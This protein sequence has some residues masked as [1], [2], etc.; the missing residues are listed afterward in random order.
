MIDKYSKIVILGAG[1]GGL[2]TAIA[3]RQK[4]FN[5]ISIYERRLKATTIG[6]GLVL[7]SNATKILNK[8]K[9]L[10]ELEKVGG[11]L[12]QMQRWT[13]NEEFLGAINVSK[14]N[15]SI[16]FKSYS[17]SRT[18]LQSI[19]LKKVYE[20][21]ISINYNHNALNISYQDNTNSIN[22][23]NDIS[24]NAQIVI[25]TDGRMNSITR[26]YV[27]GNNTPVYQGKRTLFLLKN[28]INY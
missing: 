19:L 5:N 20:L 17:I 28:S 15:N 27:N 13:K 8:L 3:L 24:V 22:F 1:I 18:D 6:A 2:T 16:G 7:W 14:I 26:Q 25:G 10:T 9:L 12:E 11:Q 4:G 21:N 23:E